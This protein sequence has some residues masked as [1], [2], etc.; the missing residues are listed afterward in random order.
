MTVQNEIAAKPQGRGFMRLSPDG[1]VR[2]TLEQFQAIPLVHLLSDLDHD[3]YPPLHEGASQ[4]HISGYTEWV[5]ETA[6][7]I[8]LGWDWRMEGASGQIHYLRTGFPRS[9]VM[10]VDDQRRDL[11]STITAKLLEATIDKADWQAVI[12]RHLMDRYA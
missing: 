4:T 8:T 11:G 2:L 9:N 6:P 10:L 1:Y 5:S 3:E 7:I 12:Q